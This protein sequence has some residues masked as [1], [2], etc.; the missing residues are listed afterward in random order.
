[1]QKP[2]DQSNACER[3]TVRPSACLAVRLSA[4]GTNSDLGST[5]TIQ[6]PELMSGT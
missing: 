4:Y 3:S 1:M 2:A 5:F 6:S